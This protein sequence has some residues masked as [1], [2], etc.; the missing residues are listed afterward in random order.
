MGPWRGKLAILAALLVQEA[1]AFEV[2]GVGFPKTGIASLEKALHALSYKVY[3]L[4]HGHAPKKDKGHGVH[5]HYHHQ[6]QQVNTHI[7]DLQ[8]WVAAIDSTSHEPLDELADTLVQRGFTAIMDV[9]LDLTDIALRLAGRFEQAKVILTEHADPQVWFKH[10]RVHMQDE[11]IQTSMWTVKQ[12][13]PVAKAQKAI[14]QAVMKERG[15]P[16]VPSEEDA[17]RFIAVYQKHNADIRAKVDKARLL[18]FVP[19]EG[20]QPLCTFLGKPVPEV[21]FPHMNTWAAEQAHLAWTRS[22]NLHFY[23]FIVVIFA[24]FFGSVGHWAWKEYYRSRV[25]VYEEKANV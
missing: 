6:P 21:D 13:G 7:E 2:I 12:G 23:G 4:A 11:R 17:E 8:K 10:Y 14:D 25:K 16:L 20:W 24:F 1:P 22:Y 9:P 18:E 19:D 3:R 5:H 15:L